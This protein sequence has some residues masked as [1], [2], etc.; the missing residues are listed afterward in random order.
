MK[1]CCSHNDSLLLFLTGMN[2]LLP[3][4]HHSP[5][6]GRSILCASS[7]PAQ[8]P[9][10]GSEL[11]PTA[12]AW[13]GSPPPTGAQIWIFTFGKSCTASHSA[14]GWG[15]RNSSSPHL[16]C[17]A[18]FN[19]LCLFLPS[20]C[21]PLAC[22]HCTAQLRLLWQTPATAIHITWPLH[23][24]SSQLRTQSPPLQWQSPQGWV[25]VSHLPVTNGPIQC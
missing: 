17:T 4:W 20:A 22:T 1:P 8:C 16:V 18:I 9:G 13:D 3:H 11:L 24:I 14:R 2:Q 5:A 15:F 25:P 23:H 10:T 19:C 12:G 21:P 7:I 6:Q